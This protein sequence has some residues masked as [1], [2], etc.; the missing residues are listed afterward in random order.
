MKRIAPNI[1]VHGGSSQCIL[2]RNED[3]AINLARVI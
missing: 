1:E 3:L 2:A